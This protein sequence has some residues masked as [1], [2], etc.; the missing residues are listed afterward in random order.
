MLGGSIDPPEALSEALLLPLL[1]LL[2][3]RTMLGRAV[4]AGEERVKT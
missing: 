1:M 4:A 2:Q 3:K